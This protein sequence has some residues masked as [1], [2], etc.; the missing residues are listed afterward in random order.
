MSSLTSKFVNILLK[1]IR[2]QK[3]SPLSKTV[4]I[5]MHD[6][7]VEDF[8]KSQ[9]SILIE[10][11]LSDV[12]S[13][14]SKTTIVDAAK[15]RDEE[16]KKFIETRA[17][18]T[19]AQAYKSRKAKNEAATTISKIYKSRFTRKNLAS[20]KIATLYKAKLEL[21]KLNKDIS[22]LLCEGLTSQDIYR[23]KIKEI[24]ITHGTPE[25]LSNLYFYFCKFGNKVLGYSKT[26]KL[27]SI[28]KE[29][30]GCVFVSTSF[31]STNLNAIIFKQSK[32]INIMQS[33]Y[34]KIALRSTD[35]KTV[36]KKHNK[37]L[38][39]DFNFTNVNLIESQF[40]DCE[41]Y[42]IDIG[43][44]NFFDNTVNT[45]N[46]NLPTFK[47][48][49]FYEG[50]FTYDSSVQRQGRSYIKPINRKYHMLRSN[51]YDFAKFIGSKNWVNPNGSLLATL[52]ERVV[53]S[54]IVFENCKFNKTGINYDKLGMPGNRNIMFL[55]CSFK[56][57]LFT[58]ENFRC[59]YFKNCTFINVHFID[60][61]FSFS[62]F[63]NCT[64]NNTT[65][66]ST[67]LNVESALRFINCKILECNFMS[68]RFSAIKEYQYQ[69]TVIFDNNNIINNTVFRECHFK[70]FKFNFDSKYNT[71][72]T[73]L[74]NLRNNDF[75]QCDLYG[76]NFDNC[77]LEGTKFAA[78]EVNHTLIVNKFNWFGNIF[79]EHDELL[80]LYGENKTEEFKELCNAHNPNGFELFK[81][82][83]VGRKLAE[84]KAAGA[85]RWTINRDYVAM[86]YSQYN[87]LNIDVLDFKNPKYNINPYDYFDVVRFGTTHHIVIV[88]AV[89]MFN[90][91]IKNCSFASAT[92]FETFD[93]TQV[94]QNYKN[95]PDLTAANFT[96]VKLI[97]A[98]FN[99]TNI[100]GTIFEVANVGGADFRNTTVNNN[101]SFQNT[102][103]IELVPYQLQRPDGTLYVQGSRNNDTGREF[104]FSDIQQAANE[105]HAR[106]KFIIDNKEQLFQ[107]FNDSGIPPESDLQFS[108][109]M[110]ELLIS[111]HGGLTKYAE[112]VV[113]SETGETIVMFLDNLRANYTTILQTQ[114]SLTSDDIKARIKK[115]F[116][117]AL[118]NYISFKLN[119]NEAEKTVMLANLVRAFSDEFM[120]HLI[121]F[122]PNLSGNWCFLQLVT[123]SVT[124]LILNTDLYM[125]NFIQ[126]YFNEIFNAHG[127]GAPSCTLGMVERWITVHSQAMEAY[128]MLLKKNDKELREL[129]SNTSAFNKI[130]HYNPLN[131]KIKDSK[132]TLAYIKEFNNSFSSEKIHNKYILHKFINLLKPYSILPEDEE[133]DVGFDLDYNVNA[134]MRKK[135]DVYIKKKIDDGSIT[136]LQDI[137]DAVVEILPLLIIEN[138]YIS[139]EHITRLENETRPKPQKIYKEKRDA[140]YNYVKEVEAKD[141]IIGLVAFFCVDLKREDMDTAKLIE[142]QEKLKSSGQLEIASIIE[143]YDDVDPTFVGGQKK[144][145]KNLRNA[146]GLSPKIAYTLEKLVESTIISK[147]KSL[148]L[149]EFSNINS[150]NISSIKDLT[151]SSS[152]KSLT[153]RF[154][155]YGIDYKP[156]ILKNTSIQDKA[157]IS[158][159]RNNYNSMQENY[160]ANITGLRS[161]IFTLTKKASLSIL[162][163]V[164]KTFKKKS[165]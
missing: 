44:L 111:S 121:M 48:C 129:T 98:N 112:K 40:I 55:N 69:Y 118:T 109:S 154:I 39:E 42:D 165:R 136:S 77:D 70:L 1:R 61:Y 89:S 64:F 148:T 145:N 78:R 93:F 4:T 12:K 101:T 83:F 149:A 120:M 107:A 15:K 17:A 52:E 26:A 36:K 65:F 21:V 72:D 75:I 41:F 31:S 146:K 158:I 110:T 24:L 84:K 115:N 50:S 90:T 108:N 143:Y 104:E 54:E 96:N 47:N 160:K 147:L 139:Q 97:N 124:F 82:E 88:P 128:L 37:F 34:N 43:P 27:S 156:I 95:K 144:N 159:I 5:K 45:I 13:D 141:Y 92:G 126:Y 117:I 22:E 142:L 131:D 11:V 105:T 23:A 57:N 94:K 157:Y 6:A 103:G 102:T 140:L 59:Y 113:V 76:V 164:S 30:V 80:F 123:Y 135:G 3:N 56:S 150:V 119:Y 25:K 58:K 122:K 155:G 63:E 152:K 8:V 153:E 33:K 162:K 20:T 161:S 85:S 19:I 14:F 9:L 106:I 68:V 132:I 116:P 134:L 67:L 87:A 99:G 127:K 10:N 51:L 91:N 29:I 73:N 16:I 130:I 138:N 100:V 114:Q 35:Y 71:R 79:L 7:E 66:R 74:L 46:N 18:N 2:T 53:S 163:R 151:T 49:N 38:R 137:Y 133:S 32:F 125:H 62:C 60:C 28:I 81:E 86:R